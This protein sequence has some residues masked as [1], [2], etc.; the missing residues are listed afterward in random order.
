MQASNRFLQ[1]GVDRRPG[2]VASQRLLLV[3]NR[4][5]RLSE[6]NLGLAA[7]YLAQARRLAPGATADRAG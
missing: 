7:S 5:C 3:A 6:V 4:E 1:C 2:L